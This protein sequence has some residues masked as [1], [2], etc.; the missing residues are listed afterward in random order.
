[1]E[2]NVQVMCKRC[3]SKVP[4]SKMRYDK[5]GANLICVSCY[6]Q[7]YTTA[8]NQEEKKEVYQS[9]VSDRIK[10][11]CLSCGFKFSR[12]EDF[13]F[14]GLCFN[15]GKPTVQREDTKQ[16]IVKDSKSLLDY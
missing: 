9:A 1:M 16:I 6:T 8:Q 4:L 15:C 2:Q 7:L 5:N 12:A 10:Y 14:G 13:S 11:H 3:S